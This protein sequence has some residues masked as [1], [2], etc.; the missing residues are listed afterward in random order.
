LSDLGIWKGGNCLHPVKLGE[1]LRKNR[2]ER[3]LRLEDLADTNISVSTISNIERG[4]PNVHMDKMKYLAQKLGLK[5][6]ELLLEEKEDDK[7]IRLRLLS[8]ENTI[9]LVDADEGFLQLEAFGPNEIK[10][11]EPFYYF[12]K[13]KCFAKKQQWAEAESNFLETLRLVPIEPHLEACNLL[14][15]SYNELANIAYYRNQI[16]EALQYVEEGIRT[17]VPDEERSYLLSILLGNKA[18]F[19]ERLG[20]LEEA[21]RVIEEMSENDLSI[22]HLDC[23]LSNYRLE[24]L[25]YRKT[26]MYI[27]AIEAVQK[28][29]EAARINGM[30]NRSFELWT[31]LGSIYYA[32]KHYDEAESCFLT[33]LQLQKKID[34]PHQ[35][36]SAFTWLGLLYI[37]ECK[38][39]TAQTYLEQAI[40]RGLQTDDHLDYLEALIAL[41]DCYRKQSMY[42]DAIKPYEQAHTMLQKTNPTSYE[43]E[44][45]IVLKMG[46]C[47]KHLDNERF[48]E[49]KDYLFDMEIRSHLDVIRHETYGICDI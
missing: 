4:L 17:F 7:K 40:Q 30:V 26:K 38:W 41:G 48:Q 42:L 12:L 21:L 32:D 5:L 9:K 44:Y 36:I 20:R 10:N 47:W 8:I 2:K 27:K 13:G 3:G 25:I 16:L 46:L 14:T 31:M 43:Q 37:E 39:E 23:L 15:A 1:M 33:A 24:A 35:L 11:Y 22:Q 19:L 18:I 6:H 45:P 29:I 34:R 28:G 49:C